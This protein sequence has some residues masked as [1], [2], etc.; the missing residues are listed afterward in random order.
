MKWPQKLDLA[1]EETG[2]PTTAG[3]IGNRVYNIEDA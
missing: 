1:D 3:E 2:N